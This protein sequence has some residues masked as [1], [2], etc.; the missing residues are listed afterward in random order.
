MFFH[1]THHTICLHDAINHHAFITLIP[2]IPLACNI[3][4]PDARESE[5]F[6]VICALSTLRSERSRAPFY[7]ITTGNVMAADAGVCRPNK[8]RT[9][10]KPEVAHHR[11]NPERHFYINALMLR[12]LLLRCFITVVDNACQVQKCDR[13]MIVTLRIMLIM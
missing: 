9:R 11:I 8:F 1:Y 12:I 5:W 13:Y 7:H 4:Y 2:L 6:A 3:F 10:I